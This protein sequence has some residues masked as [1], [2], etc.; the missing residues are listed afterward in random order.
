MLDDFLRDCE[1]LVGKEQVKV[2][3]E[4]LRYSW[5]DLPLEAA[6][7]AAVLPDSVEQVREIVLRA[8]R[9]AV[10]LYPVSTGNN[11]GYGTARPVNAASVILDLGRMNRIIEV[12]TELAYAVVEPGVTQAQLARYLADNKIPLFIDP[13]GAGPSCSILGNTLERGYGITPYGDHFMCQCG[14]EVVLADGRVLKTGFGHYENARASYLFK[15]GT[16][17]YLDGLFTQSNF[18]I[19]TKIGLW[20]MPVPEHVEACY[21]M[22]DSEARFGGLIE[23]VRTLLVQ[24]V[25]R[26]PL[27]LL[28]RNRALT[29]LMQYPWE[30]MKGATPLSEEVAAALAKRNRLGVW[31]GVGALYGT[32]EQVRAAKK[33]VK[34]ALSGKASELHFVSATTISL[35]E[36][37]QK[38]LGTLLGVDMSQTVKAIKASFGILQGVPNE[39]ALS[40]PYWRSGRTRPERDINPAKDNCGVIWLSPVIPMTVRDVAEFRGLVEPIFRRHLFDCCLTFTPVNPRCFDCTAP[41]LYNRDDPEDRDRAGRCYRDLLAACMQNG[42]IP[43]RFGIQSM[44]ELT[45]RRDPFW[46]TVETLKKALDPQGIL[47]PGRYC[48]E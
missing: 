35:L 32:K 22:A 15:W 2:G 39:V 44:A 41:I 20:L 10:S 47:S 4:A 33:A 27:N 26:G 42:F 5:G 25:V 12:N 9:H 29:L 7:P 6:A 28:H 1:T 34:A 36:K 19:V 16:G 31:N 45:G 48:R 11:W 14:M 17:P 43:Y 13:T 23:G 37:F 30:E 38:P 3:G 8:A 21:F 18:G 46:D 24:G 40:T